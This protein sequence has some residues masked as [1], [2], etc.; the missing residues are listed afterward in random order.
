LNF[1]VHGPYRWTRNPMYW[2]VLTIISGEALLL[3]S[4]TLALYAAIVAVLFHLFAVFFEERWLAE[5]FGESYHD[6]LGQ[7]NR[8]LPRPPA[9]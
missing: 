2:S 4:S 3:R 5:R 8:W 6:Y 9:R 1:V 7:V